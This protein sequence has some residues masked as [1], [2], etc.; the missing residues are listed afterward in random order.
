ME[1]EDIVDELLKMQRSP[2]YFV[3][4]VYGLVPQPLKPEYRTQMR[5]GMLLTHEDWQSFIETVT[6]DWFE[7]FVKG[8]MI[9]W[10]QWLILLC[11]EKAAKGE[12]SKKIS[13][14]SGRGIGKS[15]IFAVIIT[16]FLFCFPN[17]AIPC[18]A[19][20]KDQL[21]DAMWK[22]LAI[23]L[24]KMPKQYRSKFDYSS[25]HL[26]H[27]E[28]PDTWFARARTA[29]KDRPEALSGVHADWIMAIIDEASA[30]H[31]K[32]FEMG[33]GIL[34]SDN[35]FLIMISNG[36]TLDGYFYRSHHG[37]SS[38][39][40]HLSFSSLHSPIVNN[41]YVQSII[42]E[43][44]TGVDPKNYHTVTEWR[45]NV[46]GKFPMAGIMD[47]KGYVALLDEK[48]IVEEDGPYD[49]VGHR[50]MGVDCAGD[51][52]DLSAWVG[53]DRMRAQ[54]LG[55]EQSST[56]ASIGNKTVTFA[57]KIGIDVSFF[58]DIVLDAFGVG[59]SV[60]QEVAIITQGKGRTYPVNVGDQCELESDRELYVNQRAQAYWLLRIWC[61][62][63]GTIGRHN[64]LKK[65]LLS[66]RYR[67]VGGRIQIE[68][69]VEMKKRGIKSPNYADAFA[70]TFL[71]MIQANGM[72]A[73][74]Q[75]RIREMVD[76]EF[77]SASIFG[78]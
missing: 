40:Q 22:E 77:D 73:V 52:D 54:V 57:E 51:G 38:S 12:A 66:I 14:V 69:K 27:T 78:E 34:T 29:S 20:T 43:Y 64:A 13:V 33:Q 21:D 24:E 32:V 10:Q 28:S 71:R 17:S 9:T 35:A 74:Q 23:W 76:K 45:V 30:V 37:N 58:R 46:L 60:S 47:D 1:N 53:R 7:P 65:E 26:R 63:G 50:V 70:L 39:Y 44:C 11:L 42:D 16:W 49:F 56:P 72:S 61:K 62:K 48:D 55:E 19:V 4:K 41:N 8:E 3:E 2:V 6:V 15:S 18:T 59:H 31:E 25:D 36:T 67:R 5:L 75:N 68:S